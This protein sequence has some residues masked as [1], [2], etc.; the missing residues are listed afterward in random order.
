MARLSLGPLIKPRSIHNDLPVRR[1]FD[2]SAIHR[3]RRR[4]FE[5]HAF[6]VVAAAV[7]RTLKFVLTGFP[8]RRATEVGAPRVDHEQPVWSTVNPNSIFL[9]P[10]RVYS[11]RVIR[12][13]ADF[14]NGWRFEQ[15]A[16]EKK[17]E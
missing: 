12:G 15:S 3:P 4:P 16:R 7:A 2:V 14:E 10:F 13:I 1:K 11:N 17:T 8:I 6:I 5:I 9:L